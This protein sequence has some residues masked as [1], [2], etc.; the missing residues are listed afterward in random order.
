MK[1]TLI[2]EVFIDG[3]LVIKETT[4]NDEFDH[5]T[6]SRGVGKEVNIHI[7][8]DARKLALTILKLFGSEWDD[9]DD[10]VKFE[11]HEL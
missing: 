9:D 1:Q 7:K 11:T 8:D 3:T 6:I 5:I 4:V 2:K 10:K